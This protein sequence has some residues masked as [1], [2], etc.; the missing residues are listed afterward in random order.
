MLTLSDNPIS[1]NNVDYRNYVMAYVDTIKYLDYALIDPVLREKARNDCHDEL[2]D[3]IEKESVIAE[4]ASICPQTG[5][6]L[7]FVCSH[8]LRRLVRGGFGRG[9]S[10][11]HAGREGADRDLPREL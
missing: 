8:Y 7:Y 11:A 6:C 10:Q 9:A 5:R 3:I 2:V 1:N 4:K